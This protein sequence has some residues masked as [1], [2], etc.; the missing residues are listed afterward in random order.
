MRTA[1]CRQR[2]GGPS[3]P[4]CSFEVESQNSIPFVSNHAL[5]TPTRRCVFTWPTCSEYRRCIIQIMCLPEM[6]WS[7]RAGHNACQSTRDAI[8]DFASASRALLLSQSGDAANCAFAAFPTSWDT[9]VPDAEYRILLVLARRAGPLEHAAARICREAGAR[10]ATNVS[11]RDL[12]LDLP[13]ADGRRIEVVANN[14]PIWQGAHIGVDTTI[15]SSWRRDGEPRPGTGTRPPS[16]RRPQTAANSS[17]KLAMDAST[18]DD[19]RC[20]TSDNSSRI[21]VRK[22]AMVAALISNCVLATS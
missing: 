1:K 9:D 2:N 17:C 6:P 16:R 3:A 22:M 11:L 14:F 18:L 15:V 19:I 21:I 10:V 4:A 13:A 20:P 7:R 5:P 8:S 12:N